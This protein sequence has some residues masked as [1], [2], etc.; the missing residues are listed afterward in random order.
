M[1]T[2]RYGL[3]GIGMLMAVPCVV[4]AQDVKPPVAV[5]QIDVAAIGKDPGQ[6]SSVL[7]DMITTELA[8]KPT[9]KVIDRAQIEDLLTKQKLSLTGRGTDESAIRVGKLAGAAYIVTGGAVFAGGVVRLDLR[10]TEVETGSIVHTFKQSVK[11]SELISMMDQLG[12]AFTKELKVPALAKAADVEAPVPAVLA[13]SRGLDFEKRGKKTQA[14]QM[15]EKT[16]QIFPE[17]KD[18]QQALARVK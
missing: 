10:M 5:M 2:L 8:K 17:Y 7:L 16:L 15:F 6:M 4:A 3:L 11:E 1:R 13:Y 9:I 14:A 12:D 18:A